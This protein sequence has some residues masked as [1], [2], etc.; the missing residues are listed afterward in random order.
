[1]SKETENNQDQTSSQNTQASTETK[2]TTDS[3]STSTEDNSSN[4]ISDAIKSTEEKPDEGDNNT[5]DGSKPDDNSGANGPDD[6]GGDDNKG[7]KPS[8]DNN[9]P[10]YELVFAEDSPLTDEQIDAIANLASEKGWSKDQAEEYAKSVEDFYK[11]GIEHSNKPRMEYYQN[12]IK[13]FDNDPEFN[14]D[15]KVETY[16]HIA[17]AA[18]K[19]G[20]PELLQELSKPEI[21]NNYELAKFLSKIGKM[22]D[23]DGPPVGSPGDGGEKLSPEDAKLRRMYPS[24]FEKK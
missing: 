3:P 21:G 16:S 7:D 20:T 19:F 6:K 9:E 5:A 12:E 18:K 10:E 11:Q 4:P 2:T 13:K 23:G 24:L 8:G 14:G 1:M 15:K 17:K 22:M